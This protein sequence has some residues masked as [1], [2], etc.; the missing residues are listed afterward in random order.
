[1]NERGRTGR[2]ASDDVIQFTDTH[3][4]YASEVVDHWIAK[5]CTDFNDNPVFFHTAFESVFNM[6]YIIEALEKTTSDIMERMSGNKDLVALL[7]TQMY[8][9]RAELVRQ[10]EVWD[11][12]QASYATDPAVQAAVT[13]AMR[14]FKPGNGGESK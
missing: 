2:E 11:R 4:A 8:A 7:W 13:E 14:S 10:C 5:R 1:M 6:S 12:T 3:A 9:L